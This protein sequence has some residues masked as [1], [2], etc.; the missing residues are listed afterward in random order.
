MAFPPSSHP[1]HLPVAAGPQG[2]PCFEAPCPLQPL[3]ATTPTWATQQSNLGTPRPKSANA[4]S[5]PSRSGSPHVTQGDLSLQQPP[6][7]SPVSGGSPSSS[8]LS[9]ELQIICCFSGISMGQSTGASSSAWPGPNSSTQTG[10]FF[11]CRRLSYGPAS[12]SRPGGPPSTCWSRSLDSCTRLAITSSPT[13]TMQPTPVTSP[14]I[15]LSLTPLCPKARPAA[16]TNKSH[17]QMFNIM[18]LRF[19]CM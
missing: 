5:M 10:P 15:F 9:S 2:P 11:Q 7:C 18:E 4:P 8:G 6:S 3:L 17:N 1:P 16:D 14:A 19:S 12:R 13:L